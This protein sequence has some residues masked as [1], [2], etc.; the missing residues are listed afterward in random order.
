MKIKRMAATFGRLEGAVLELHDGLNILQAP[1]EGGKSTWCAFLRAMLY[2]IPTRERD[3]R[4][5]LAEKNRYAPWSGSPMAGEVLLTWQGRDIR[6]RRFAKGASPFGGFEAVDAAT[7]EPVPGLTGE[8]CGEALL[9]VGREVF[10]RSA[11]VGQSGLPVDAD[12][13]LERR[14]AALVSSGE[15]DVSFS[16]TEQTLKGWLN[17]RKHNKTGLIPRLEGELEEVT[18]QQA[19][20]LQNQR[21]LQ[22][23][24]AQAEALEARRTELEAEQAAQR[25]RRDWV[26]LDQYQSAARELE[27]AQSQLSALEGEAGPLPGKDALRE[28]QGELVYYNTLAASLK[29]AQNQQEPVRARLEAAQAGAEDPLFPGLDP[30][31]AWSK[32][33]RDAERVRELEKPAGKGLLA[34]GVLLLLAAA[35][36]GAGAGLL[37][38]PLLLLPAGLGVAAGVIFLFTARRKGAERRRERERLLARYHA[39]YS[40]DILARANAYREK[41]VTVEEA[42]R[43][44]Q[45]VDGS[46]RDLTAQREALRQKLLAFVHAFAPEVTDPFGVSA[47]LSR[48][49]SLDER[50]AT[51]RVKVQGAQKLL[52][53]L[54]Q[55]TA[56]NNVAVR[57]QGGAPFVPPAAPEHTPQQT[58]AALSAVAGELQRVRDALSHA[59]GQRSALG[60]PEELEGRREALTQALEERRQEHQALSLALEALEEANGQLR[61][62]FS[63]ALNRRAGELFSALTGGKYEEVT[64]TRELEASA[65]EAGDIRPRRALTLSRGT[66][67]Q[68]Y[69]AVRLAVC[70]LALP[71]EDPAPLVLDDALSD[72]DDGRMALALECLRD[73]AR[74]R[75]VL[76]FTCHS[77]EQA[78]LERNEDGAS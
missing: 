31:E 41:W 71:G 59:R 68:L 40:D 28:A 4:T 64:L 78:W 77:R 73:L 72:F 13:E 74:K 56:E 32:A 50:L 16:E 15:E 19:A 75:Q 7:G 23:S 51:A 5:T 17:H 55:P 54:P 48:A 70:E 25:A 69:L 53:S 33:S 57:A 26:L 67:D 18:R 35:A 2:G 34:A 27:E 39:E 22:E 58:A 38:Q 49:L 63:P 47:A 76:L 20:A 10:Q 9:G 62:R 8:N 45:A 24:Q 21:L 52:D 37:R 46:I 36:C 44:V 60:D 12:P 43:A 66:V 3:T 30:E 29:E 1:N 11:F 14:I 42:R 61:A 65:R 6:I